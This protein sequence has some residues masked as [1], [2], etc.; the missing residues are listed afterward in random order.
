MKIYIGADHAGFEIKG[1]LKTYLSKS[2]YE[3]EDKGNF[4]FDQND[5]YPDFVLPVATAVAENSES[6]GIIFGGSGQGEAIVA[7]RVKGIRAVVLNHYNEDVIRLS[8]EHND[9]NILSIGARFLSEGE[10]EKA[11]SMWLQTSFSGENRHIRRIKK[12]EEIN[13]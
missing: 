5:D 10:V 11:V 1:K 4:V 9:A 13:L 2:G 12:I 3:V 6:V 8:R 7:N